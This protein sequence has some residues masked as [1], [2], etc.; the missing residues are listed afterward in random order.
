MKYKKSSASA[1]VLSMIEKLIYD[2]KEIMADSKKAE[3]E[4][5]AAYEALVSDSN[6][7]IK[8]LTKTVLSKTDAKVQANK[9]L[10][11]TNLDIK[12]NTKDLA[13]L[14]ATDAGLHKD[15]DFVLKNFMVRQQARSEEMES[16]RQAKLLLSGAAA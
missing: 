10:T 9:D 1:G 16:L 14:A 11:Q 6:D 8:S 3:S 5:Q 7:T 4:A 15:C 12:A 2:A 13:R